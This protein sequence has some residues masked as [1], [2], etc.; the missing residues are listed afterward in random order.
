MTRG[1]L[2]VYRAGAA[3][4][5]DKSGTNLLTPK[6][7]SLSASYKA[8]QL[9]VAYRLSGFDKENDMITFLVLL[10]VEVSLACIGGGPPGGGAC[11]APTIWSC[12]APCQPRPA[13]VLPPIP[14][15]PPPPPIP[16]PRQ[17]QPVPLPPFPYQPRYVYAKVLPPQPSPYGSLP[18]QFVPQPPPSPKFGG[19]KCINMIWP[20]SLS[21]NVFLPNDFKRGKLD[22]GRVSFDLVI[23]NDESESPGSSDRMHLIRSYK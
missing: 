8:S 7:S 13:P 17:P 18:L 21:A 22:V 9:G 1:G 3:I 10:L 14:P 2:P 19:K 5:L 16:P 23:N 4:L 20:K 6:G 15:P 12:S 11:C